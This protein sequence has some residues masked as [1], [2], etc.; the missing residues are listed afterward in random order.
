MAK[1]SGPR[2]QGRPVT[3]FTPKARRRM[4][5]VLNALPWDEVGEGSQQ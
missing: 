5:R 2:R 4:R 3:G 1:A